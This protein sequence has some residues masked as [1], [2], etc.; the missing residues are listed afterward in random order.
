VWGAALEG[1]RSVGESRFAREQISES[2]ASTSN[3]ISDDGM[4]RDITV[5]H[6]Q[7]ACLS[8]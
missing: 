4:N 1:W 6:E 5:R 7:P 2:D 3:L 8:A